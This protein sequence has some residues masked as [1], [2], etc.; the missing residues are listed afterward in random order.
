MP[1]T[2]FDTVSQWLT[3]LG[4]K[5][6]GVVA[7]R[8]AGFNQ[9][10]SSGWEGL[11]TGQREFEESYPARPSAT[12]SIANEFGEIRVTT[13]DNPV[14]QVKAQVLAGAENDDLARELSEA[15]KITVTPAAEQIEIR[16]E[17]PDTREKGKVAM[18]VNYTVTVPS[19]ANVIC[20]N[21]FGDTIVA[22]VGGTVAVD[23]RF[24]MVDLREISGLVTVRAWGEFPLTARDLR[25]GGFF[26]LQ[27]T[28]AEFANVGGTLNVGSFTGSVA[29]RDLAPEADLDV[30]SESGPIHLYVPENA[31]PDISATAFFGTVKSDTVMEQTSRG[32][33]V[34]ARGAN[35][36]SKQ[37]VTL[38]VS[39]D[40]I[41]VHQEGLKPPP[42]PAVKNG[43]EYV[44][45]S[46]E[47]AVDLTAG[48]A[49]A[50]EAVPGDV[51]IHGTDGN[52]VEIKATR[53]V[54]VESTSNA[55]AAIEAL[56]LT[57]EPSPERVRIVTAV[58][59]NLSSLGCTQF[60]IDLEIGVPRT[61]SLHVTA[62]NGATSVAGMA[63]SVVIIQKKGSVSAENCKRDTGTFELT[64]EAGDVSLTD[65]QGPVTVAAQQGMV[66][67]VNVYG[68]QAITSVQAKT[69]IESPK[70]EVVVRNRGADVSILA[71]DG[72]L[73]EY[74]VAVE[75]GTLNIVIPPSS[76]ATLYVTV[77]NGQVRNSSI[78]L[79]GS[80]EP[81]QVSK[82]TGRVNNGTN[83]V[84]LQTDGG[85]I[86]ID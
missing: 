85:D 75:K 24:G 46:M 81:Q 57:V 35:V 12:V 51:R 70:G 17:Y 22:N 64:N 79:N 80:L 50:V 49:V 56:G 25:L 65:C 61:A 31:A 72:I 1:S 84:E 48:A 6:E 62:E 21:N 76:D 83:R 13:W 19:T 32:D 73:G 28:Q 39:F 4:E 33:M 26:Q 9:Q 69:L 45:R 8:F 29:L 30:T 15:I 54:R 27:G 77:K 3:F 41:Y 59:D 58:R 66:K 16:T 47:Q 43:G 74:N 5:T 55:Q 18:A 71:L 2:F 11:K 36:D 14:V 44:T 63:N 42:P 38:Q 23:S 82:F 20:K 40:T 10:G 86:Y 37:Q 67:S 60:R 52:R 34:V 68:K 53:V 78:T 7:P